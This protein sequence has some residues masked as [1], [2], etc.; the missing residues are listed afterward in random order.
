MGK[1]RVTNAI[2]DDA[3]CRWCR[4]HFACFNRPGQA[5]YGKKMVLRRERREAKAEAQS[6]YEDSEDWQQI[7][8]L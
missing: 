6:Q 7:P 5:R 1:R 2:E 4:R 3:T 8:W